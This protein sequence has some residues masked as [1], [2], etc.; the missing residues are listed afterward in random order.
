MCVVSIISVVL[1]LGAAAWSVRIARQFKDWRVW[2]ING[3]LIFMTI[4]GSTMLW[5][6]RSHEPLTFFCGEKDAWYLFGGILACLSLYFL[7]GLLRDVQRQRAQHKESVKTLQLTERRMRSIVEN[8][9]GAVTIKDSDARYVFI[10][11]YAASLLGVTADSVVG[12][13]ALEVVGPENIGADT[14]DNEVLNTGR[15]LQNLEDHWINPNGETRY[16]M[17]SKSPLLDAQGNVDSIITIGFDVSKQRFAEAALQEREQRYQDLFNQTPVGVWDEDYSKVKDLVDA[18]RRR[19]VGD[20]G[21]YFRSNPDVFSRVVASIRLND[22]NP[23]VVRMYGAEDRQQFFAEFDPL[24]PSMD[25]Y[26]LRVITALTEGQ[27]NVTL[28]H[29]ISTRDGREVYVLTTLHVVD[30]GTGSWTRVVSTDED[31]TKFKVAERGLLE[32]KETAEWAS[33]AKSEFLAHM[34]HELR[35]P[36]NAILGFTQ[37][38]SAEIFGKLGSPK[39]LEYSKDINSAAQHLLDVINDI[40]DI[41]K[42]E[43]GE[44]ILEETDVDPAELFITCLTMV[45]GRPDV[46]DTVLEYEVPPWAPCLLADRRF[47][48]QILINLLTNAAKFTPDSGRVMMKLALRSDGGIDL[49]VED[50]GPGIAPEDLAKVL[51]PFGQVRGSSHESHEGTGLGLTLSKRLSELHDADLSVASTLGKGTTVTVSFPPRRTIKDI[52]A[53]D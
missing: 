47:V 13:S 7:T 45:K 21:G 19:G 50:T 5:Q 33:R 24:R 18:L 6:G 10:N 49:I 22:I 41:S 39:Y 42:I 31:I 25:G 26:Y 46:G 17:A 12:K 16:T 1:Y 40:L 53:D 27:Q 29:K 44:A 8:I 14:F 36:M 48:S 15:S 9:P 20:L 43:A 52:D 23:A 34:S 11:S 28:E 2:C 32:A 51:E 4:Y 38:I 37:M 3:L 30:D 35:T